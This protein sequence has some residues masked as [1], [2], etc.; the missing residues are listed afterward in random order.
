MW[1]EKEIT[2]FIW[3]Q[4]TGA[5]RDIECCLDF[6]SLP[7]TILSTHYL[8]THL[9]LV[10][11]YRTSKWQLPCTQVLYMATRTFGPRGH[12]Q[13]LGTGKLSL[14][15]GHVYWSKTEGKREFVAD[16]FPSPWTGQCL[17][18]HHWN[19]VLLPKGCEPIKSMYF[20]AEGELRKSEGR[21]LRPP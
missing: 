1:E 6:A 7:G 9:V 21:P 12:V 19:L 18:V 14:T 8:A 11:M 20:L 15:G 17:T 2:K 13:N 4:I 3:L 5:L 16:S 10:A